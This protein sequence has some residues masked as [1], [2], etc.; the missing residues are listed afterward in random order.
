MMRR[1]LAGAAMVGVLFGLSATA[2]SADVGPSTVNKGNEVLS[3][4]AV[5]DD[6]TLANDVLNDSLKYINVLSVGNLQN[7]DVNLLNNE[8]ETR[9]HD[10]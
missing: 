4:W 6:V 8:L 5:V 7:V 3:Q 1:I 2:A 9:N 10:H